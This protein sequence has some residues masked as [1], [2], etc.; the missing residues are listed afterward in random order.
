MIQKD[1]YQ[2]FMKQLKHYRLTK[3][4][5][6]WN[7]HSRNTLLR[8]S[9]NIHKLLLQTVKDGV[10]IH[11]IVKNVNLNIFFLHYFVKLNCN[12]YRNDA[13]LITFEASN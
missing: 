4:F 9:E 13:Q 12:S 1:G 8:G 3:L 11:K 10:A 6:A 7:F 2:Y 5:L